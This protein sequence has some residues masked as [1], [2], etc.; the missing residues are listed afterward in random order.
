MQKTQSMNG[1]FGILWNIISPIVLCN[2]SLL[3][4]RNSYYLVFVDKVNAIKKS[5]SDAAAGYF[6]CHDVFGFLRNRL[7]TLL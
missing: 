7:P 4:C 1:I 6:C 3:L 2:P 5:I